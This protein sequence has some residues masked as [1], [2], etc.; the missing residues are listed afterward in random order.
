MCLK[1]M[2]GTWVLISINSKTTQNKRDRNIGWGERR[3]Q[4]SY[5][6]PPASVKFRRII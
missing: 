5:C 1:R 4:R 3:C 6:A 2:S